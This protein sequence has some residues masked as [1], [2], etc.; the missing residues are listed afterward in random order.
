MLGNRTIKVY[1]EN[2]NKNY[3]GGQQ[4]N[5]NFSQDTG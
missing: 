1:T 2:S 3:S 4:K 5:N